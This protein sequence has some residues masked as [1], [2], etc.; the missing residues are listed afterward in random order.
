MKKEITI[1]DRIDGITTIIVDIPNMLYEGAFASQPLIEFTI[2]RANNMFP[3]CH[4]DGS[5]DETIMNGLMLKCTLVELGYI[6]KSL[7]E[8]TGSSNGTVVDFKRSEIIIYDG[9]LE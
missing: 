7:E 5:F 6:I 1:P 8:Q 4:F 2:R 3:E 9:L